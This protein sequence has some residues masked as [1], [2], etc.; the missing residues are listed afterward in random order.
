MEMSK[1]VLALSQQITSAFQDYP[2][3]GIDLRVAPA[4]M[5]R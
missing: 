2:P 4:T 5:N 1:L 3:T